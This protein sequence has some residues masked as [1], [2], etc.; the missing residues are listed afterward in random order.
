MS[1]SNP[2]PST[3]AGAHAIV[4][5][6][7]IAGLMSA[8]MLS[9]HFE[10]VTLVE[11]DRFPD[12]PQPRKGVPQAL[13]IHGLL[14]RG[15]DILADILPG[16]RQEL[17]AAGGE[18]LDVV[19]TVASFGAGSWRPRFPSGVKAASMSRL[20]L[21]WVIRQRLQAL[22]NVR[23]LD[24]REAVGFLTSADRT[25]VTGLQ[26]QAP[27]G[28]QVETLEAALVVDAS[29]RGSRMPQWLE[30]LGYP[31]VEET[32][33]HV[34]VGYATRIYR[35]PRGFAPGWRSM[36][37]APELPRER[38]LGI[39]QDIE[40]HRWLVTLGGWLGDFPA[41]ADEAVFLEFARG[42][43]QP[44]V[45]EAIKNAEPLGPV[46]LYRFPH[47][48]RRHYERMSRFPEGLAV[49]GDAFCSFNP[50]YGQGMSTGAMQ[51]EALGESLRQGVHGAADRYRR[52]AGEILAGPWALAT[53]GDL[54]FPEVEGKRPPGFG[55]MTWY[56]NR[57][58]QL[59][60]YD[61]EALRTFARVQ[62]MIDSP[63]AMFSPRMVLKVLTVQPGKAAQT[64]GPRPLAAASPRAA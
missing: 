36:A 54:A 1:T 8:G 51:A 25:R 20:L 56:G 22:A 58:Q 35:K 13:H 30:A 21:E 9:R 2:S 11:R 23:I 39:I 16:I 61:A 29:G 4:F 32:R 18:F 49:V 5:G 17:E 34:D 10:R 15:M 27:G 46:H 33:I 63:A 43:P 48:Q 28:G 14:T 31:R 60:G 62:H 6:G 44:H 47:H 50:I 37:L 59:A 24:G 45:Y 19:E 53:A 12:G 41:T 55:L 38:R 40:D 3:P 26:V 64:P 57:F 52:R 42:L 7:S